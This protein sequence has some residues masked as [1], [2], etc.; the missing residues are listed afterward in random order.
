VTLDNPANPILRI[1]QLIYGMT[2]ALGGLIPFRMGLT[3]SRRALV[4][5][6]EQVGLEVYDSGYLIHAPR[7]LA[8]WAGEWAARRRSAGATRG[9][10]RLLAVIEQTAHRRRPG[11]GRALH[12]RRVSRANDVRADEVKVAAAPLPS[13]LGRAKFAEHWLRFTYLRC[14]PSRSCRTSTLP[15]TCRRARTAAAPIYRA[16]R[17]RSWGDA[18]RAAV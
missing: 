14:L 13:W 18:G 4:E 17:S 7:V 5:A 15:S 2:G 1:R 8:L 3:L 6:A 12:L 16:I 9:L 11:A 10:T